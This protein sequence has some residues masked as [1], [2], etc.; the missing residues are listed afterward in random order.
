MGTRLSKLRDG[1]DNEFERIQ[2]EAAATR[3]RREDGFA[4]AGAH[5]GSGGT[6]YGHGGYSGDSGGTSS[7]SGGDSGGCSS[8]GGDSGGGSSS[9]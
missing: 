3:R 7:S 2:S 4:G 6:G 8:S 5:V 1:I 9:Y